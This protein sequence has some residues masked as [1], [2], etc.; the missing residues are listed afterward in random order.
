[1]PL[2]TVTES[3]NTVATAAVEAMKHSERCD[4]GIATELN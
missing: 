3:N 4:K 2:V 1:M